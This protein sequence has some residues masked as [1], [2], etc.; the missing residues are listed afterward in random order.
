M[1]VKWSKLISA[2]IVWSM[3]SIGFLG[4]LAVIPEDSMRVTATTLNV[5]GEYEKITYALENATD[6]DRIQVASGEYLENI[7]LDKEVQLIGSGK[8]ATTINCSEGSY[9]VKILVNNVTIKGFEITESGNDGIYVSGAHSNIT[10]E[11]CI[12]SN[13]GGYGIFHGGSSVEASPDVTISE[14][15]I[16]Y[17]TNDGILLQYVSSGTIQNNIVSHNDFGLSLSYSSSVDVTNNQI[18]SNEMRGIDIRRSDSIRIVKNDIHENGLYGITTQG[19][20]NFFEDNTI[21][22]H[23]YSGISLDE[24]DLNEIIKNQINHNTNRGITASGSIS[25]LTIT[26]NIIA[27]NKKGI[28]I[29]ETIYFPHNI[30][31]KENEIKG[32]SEEGIRIGGGDSYFIENNSITENNKG[33]RIGSAER[34]SI[35]GNVISS[36]IDDGIEI[37]SHSFWTNI[38]NNTITNNDVGI[39][40]TYSPHKEIHY[41][42]IADNTKSGINA[43]GAG[44]NATLNHWGAGTGPYN[45]NSNP[46]GE[47]NAVNDNVDFIPWLNMEY[48]ID[49]SIRE[50]DIEFIKKTDGN[51]TIS[52]KVQS[53]IEY[54]SQY[55][56][57]VN[58]SC[59][60][61]RK[62][63]AQDEYSE[64]KT[65]TNLTSDGIAMF[66][67]ELEQNDNIKIIVDH[68]NTIKERDENNNTAERI[69]TSGD[70]IDLF[71]T[72][73][74]ISF[75]EK[76]EGSEEITITVVT[77][78]TGA[79]NFGPIEVSLEVWR[80]VETDAYES[81]DIL[82]SNTNN[83]L[84]TFTFELK[85]LDK[86]NVT[87]DSAKTYEEK[88]EKN[89]NVTK[90]YTYEVKTIDL[91]ISDGG[92]SFTSKKD[93]KTITITVGVT[94]TGMDDMVGVI[95]RFEIWRK[96]NLNVVQLIAS[97]DQGV[98]GNTASYEFDLENGDS[99]DVMVDPD[100][101][102]KESNENNNDATTTY[103]LG[104]LPPDLTIKEIIIVQTIEGGKLVA[105]KDTA[106]RVIVDPGIP[107]DLFQEKV[108]H[109]NVKLLVNNVPHFPAENDKTVFVDS[110]LGYK[111]RDLFKC[112]DSFNFFIGELEKGEVWIK[113]IVDY[114]NTIQERDESNNEDEMTRDVSETQPLRFWFRQLYSH[115]I[116]VVN[117]KT[118]GEFEEEAMMFMRSTFPIAPENME[119][120]LGSAIGDTQI[121]FDGDIA[122]SIELAVWFKSGLTW[123]NIWNDPNYDYCVVILPKDYLGSSIDGVSL[124]GF[125]NVPIVDEDSP[126]SMAHEIGHN[127]GLGIPEEYDI[128]YG[129]AGKLLLD[130][131]L[132][133]PFLKE[134]GLTL[135]NQNFRNYCFMGASSLAWVEP[136]CYNTL[137]DAFVVPTVDTRSSR[138]IE[139]SEVLFVNGVINPDDS[140]KL[141]PWYRLSGTYTD[142]GDL[143]QGDY[144]IDCISES[145]EVINS[146]EF[147]VDFTGSTY[148]PST[149][150]TSELSSYPFSFSIPYPV[151]TVKVVIRHNNSVLKEIVPSL[152]APTVELKTPNGGEMIN[153]IYEIT[154]EG[155]DSD[156]DNLTYSLLYSNDDGVIWEPIIRDMEGN[157][158]SWDTSKTPGGDSCLLKIIATDG[159]NIGDDTSDA[160]FSI[161]LKTPDVYINSHENG[162]MIG[163]G[164]DTVFKGLSYDREDGG[165]NGQN[166]KWI[167][168]K[169]GIIGYG[170][171]IFV[172]NLSEGKHTITLFGVDSTGSTGQATFNI[173]VVKDITPP[174][175]SMVNVSQSKFEKNETVSIQVMISDEIGIDPFIVYVS[176]NEKAISLYYNES[177]GL[178]EGEFQA[179]MIPGRYTL[180]ITAGDTSGNLAYHPSQ[181]IS[182]KSDDE[183]D[184]L[185]LLLSHF[186]EILIVIALLVVILGV[187][188]KRNQRK[189]VKE[190][191]D[192]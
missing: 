1:H 16:I 10:I 5:P 182:V 24:A 37:V 64:L 50:E 134:K 159:F 145:G 66:H 173:T 153:G 30:S 34:N 2:C 69:Y 112:K 74:D 162:D 152:N 183:D 20:M 180:N 118:G 164:V 31:I 26:D 103:T 115:K 166:L 87:V 137:F 179:P 157:S 136:S 139:F 61:L 39:K 154:W 188:R 89:N 55:F 65:L 109:V 36:N 106:V 83:G 161:V 192:K 40:N 51:V 163:L 84:A 7:V 105:G 49:L 63:D 130:M 146:E 59:H 80:K 122:D 68:M 78:V 42:V 9:G 70:L 27:E 99:V 156:V 11:D 100:N 86:V 71:I 165:L 125:R 48:V 8:E 158:Y 178:Y 43:N 4:L 45:A 101:E 116:G 77:H 19:N 108:E 185:S 135:S 33:I 60:I 172:T 104:L 53:S 72:D 25:N 140:V 167:S 133:D 76:I 92:M 126:Y 160:A 169:D 44:L 107:E 121:P 184:L 111:G 138:D 38:T 181:V 110:D 95:V 90:L 189:I 127:Y 6:G 147:G 23:A 151:G 132:Y 113:A 142:M 171:A 170:N 12:I 96:D 56:D 21:T 62:E 85:D 129:G 191:K 58:V 67:Y 88:N 144:F 15:Q 150:Q 114:D 47:G 176:I 41:N 143:N 94:A 186:M 155:S 75:S 97:Y 93:S 91:S 168:D 18:F 148:P 13:C 29:K 190:G 117:T 177:S 119:S 81:M 98:S 120:K 52:A 141:R 79:E 102:F 54:G 17:C 3:I 174:A 123:Y 73:E 175:I 46:E 57:P 124:R 35:S 82:K 128:Y 32:N 14:N 28:W 22:Y 131:T 149:A 187:I